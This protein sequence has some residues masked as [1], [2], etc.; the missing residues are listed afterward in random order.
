MFGH[1]GDR[2][3]QLHDLPYAFHGFGLS[4][5]DALQ[6]AAELRT[7]GNRGDL[8]ARQSNIDAVS[9]RSIDLA[10]RIHALGRRAD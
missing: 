7:N 4:L 6:F 8:H 2:I 1:D 5:V 3:L 9:R 10:G